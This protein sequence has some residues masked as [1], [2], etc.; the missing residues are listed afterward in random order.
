MLYAIEVQD[1]D[2][3]G[4]EL[5]VLSA[6]ETGRGQIDYGEG[7]SGLVRALRTAGARHVLVTLHEVSDPGA[8]DFMERFYR[9]WLGQERFYHRWLGRRHSDPVAAFRAA[10]L[11][12]IAAPP[13][14][15][16]RRDRTWAQFVMIGV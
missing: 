14:T 3:E 6:C 13:D 10:Q 11:E 12:T 4:T 5:V 9:C 16:A 1:L 8:A 7:V 15:P 2:L